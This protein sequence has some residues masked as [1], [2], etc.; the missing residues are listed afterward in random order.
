MAKAKKKNRYFLIDYENVHTGGLTGLE[1]LSKSDT[2][3]VFY[4]EN[5]DSLTFEV[6]QSFSRCRAKT[7]YIKVGTDGQN[8]LDF[9]LSSFVG[10]L[11][12]KDS[13]ARCYIVSLDKGYT[14]VLYFWSGMEKHVSL[15]PNIAAYKNA[16]I[17]RSDIL[18]ALEPLEQLSEEEKALVTD[19]VWERVRAGS[20]QIG[21]I[22]VTINNALMR[23]FGNERTKEIFNALRVIIR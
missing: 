16:R 11:I 3:Y 17:K 14:N 22:R 1:E 20:P 13:D 19:I 18:C 7:K 6:M 2:V 12:G 10:Y 23:Q 5:A 4:S 15:I 8:A 9:Q 21:H